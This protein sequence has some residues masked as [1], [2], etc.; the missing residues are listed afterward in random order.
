MLAQ[1]DPVHE[2]YGRSRL[3]LLQV[4][5]SDEFWDQIDANPDRLVVLM[6]KSYG[7]RPCKVSAKHLAKRVPC[8]CWAAAEPLKPLAG[9]QQE[10]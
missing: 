5:S 2:P 4:K 8:R 7:C 6:S 9:L 10:V 1:S 3:V